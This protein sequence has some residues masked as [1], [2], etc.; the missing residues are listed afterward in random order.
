M[1]LKHI[2]AGTTFC[3]CAPTWFPQVQMPHLDAS[4][5]SIHDPSVLLCGRQPL[6]AACGWIKLHTTKG[7]RRCLPL[8]RPSKSRRTCLETSATT[9]ARDLR[10][11]LAYRP[12][13]SHSTEVLRCFYCAGGC[14]L[15]HLRKSYVLI[16]ANNIAAKPICSYHSQP[17]S[18]YVEQLIA[19]LPAPF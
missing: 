2:S 1:E 7:N 18:T 8:I 10:C 6:L 12:A 16:I 13:A 15:H 17:Q 9:T 14:I 3:I 5:K 19:R 4:H 11:H